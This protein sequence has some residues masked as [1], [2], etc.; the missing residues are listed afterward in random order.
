MAKPFVMLLATDTL[1]SPN[2]LEADDAPLIST[3][4]DEDDVVDAVEAVERDNES[5]GDVETARIG[6]TATTASAGAT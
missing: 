2:P 6:A 1:D 5:E 4:E 3:D